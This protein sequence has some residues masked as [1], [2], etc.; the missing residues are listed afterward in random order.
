MIRLVQMAFR[1]LTRNTRRSLLTV[2]AIAVGLAV[3]IFTIT[4]ATG[5]YDAMTRQG[6]SQLA[7]H[8]VVQAPG[9]QQD[10]EPTLVVTRAD[11]VAAA[12]QR[13]FPGAVITRR[14]QLAGLLMS[15]S[16]SVGAAVEGVDPLA[17]RK[18][19]DLAD[20]LVE[21]EWL[22]A[23]DTRGALIGR[24]MADQLD[25]GPGDK[26]VFMGQ[27]K[28]QPEMQSRLFRVRGIFATGSAE[29]DGFLALVHLD[30]ARELLTAPDAA[31]QVAVH[32]PDASLADAAVPLARAAIGRDDVEVLH[33]KQ[34]IPEL[35]AMIQVD[36]ESTDV[37]MS[38]IG[39]I[40]ALGVLNTVLMSVLERT[41][42]F[43]VL[44]AVGMT[45]RGVAGLVLLEGLALGVVGVLAG[46]ALGFAPSWYIVHHGIDLTGML[47]AETM[48]SGGVSISAVIHGAW[49]VP[50]LAKYAA[51]ALLFA[52]L[53]AA[54][55]AW[56]VSRLQPVDAMRHH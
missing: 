54:W 29:A 8:V 13:A 24:G 14:I 50:R 41:R 37:L 27:Q 25:V 12:L 39:F 49:D 26:I 18:V 55:P 44:M 7:G 2:A 34:A 42:E 48:D 17:E 10:R 31:N 46:I 19:N 9:Y 30:A 45:R 21:G 5:S 36:K 16:S 4:F 53:A 33:W 35:Y 1:N 32:L 3:M 11:E 15:S 38:V 6:I 47:G 56:R 51:A 52:T 40:V 23:E 20:K 28:G 43:G 22:G